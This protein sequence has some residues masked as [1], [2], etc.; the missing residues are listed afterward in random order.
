MPILAFVPK[1]VQIIP[2]IYEIT[3]VNRITNH[4]YYNQHSPITRSVTCNLKKKTTFHDFIYQDREKFNLPVCVVSNFN[5]FSYMLRPAAKTPCQF[6][7]LNLP[8]PVI[9]FITVGNM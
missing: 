6:G 5:L 2:N 1:Q 7:V 3:T 8:V 9:L 4:I